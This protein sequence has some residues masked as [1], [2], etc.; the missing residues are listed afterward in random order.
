MGFEGRTEFQL[1][2]AVHEPWKG[3]AEICLHFALL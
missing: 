3:V 2:V 1:K